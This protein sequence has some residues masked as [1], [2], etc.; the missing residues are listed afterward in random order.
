MLTTFVHL[1][2][3]FEITAVEDLPETL[4]WK[5]ENVAVPVNP[6]LVKLRPKDGI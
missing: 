2:T 6:L 1:W 3:H 4:G 5:E